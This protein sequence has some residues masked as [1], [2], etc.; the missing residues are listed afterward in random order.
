MANAAEESVDLPLGQLTRW[1]FDG[2]ALDVGC[3]AGFH[4][5]A[6][7]SAELP[8]VGCRGAEKAAANSKAA[9]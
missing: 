8:L 7:V 3:I 5:A 4:G 2:F 1:A 6:K 9:A